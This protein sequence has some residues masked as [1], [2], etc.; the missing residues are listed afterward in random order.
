MRFTRSGR[1]FV[2]VLAVALPRE[3][4]EFEISTVAEPPALTSP[5]DELHYIFRAGL[6]L[7]GHVESVN[8][9]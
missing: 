3:P 5:A 6:R 1:E 2:E 4:A 9:R 7:T 8:T